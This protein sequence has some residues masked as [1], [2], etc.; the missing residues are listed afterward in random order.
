MLLLKCK[1]YTFNT[2]VPSR[3]KELLRAAE[4]ARLK[5]MLLNKT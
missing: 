4:A 1:N 5:R 2:E 3:V